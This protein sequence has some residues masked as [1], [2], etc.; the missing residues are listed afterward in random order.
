MKRTQII[1]A[2]L[3]ILMVAGT[4][5]AL[6]KIR[7]GRKLGEPGVKTQ[8][9]ADSKNLEILLPEFIPGYTSE[10]ATQSEMELLKLPADTSF[11]VR[12]YQAPDGFYSQ[13]SVVTMGS[14]R[15]SIHK[16]QICMTGQGWTIDDSASGQE[17]IQMDRPFPY[18]LRVNKLLA[19]AR[20]PKDGHPY[21]GIYVYWFVDADHLTPNSNQWMLWWLPRDL[22][23]HG[24]LERW[25]YISYFTICAP[26]SEDVTFGRLKQ[27][28]AESVPEYQL[29]PA[30]N[31]KS[32]V[33]SR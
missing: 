11:R 1:L 7:S 26:G 12:V 5:L 9:R 18:T 33:T 20:D 27:F 31:T 22:L 25:S 15:S 16:P 8:P 29:V 3:V 4:A 23:L 2:T 21:R 17:D 6:T 13:V 14:D 32:A 10:I 24:V 30:E 19:T 28:I